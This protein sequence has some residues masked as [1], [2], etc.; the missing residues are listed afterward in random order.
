VR[1]LD[2]K[3]TEL[4]LLSLGDASAK[5]GLPAISSQNSDVWRVSNDLGAQVPLSQEAYVN[6]F[7]K[8]P[9]VPAPPETAPPASAPPAKP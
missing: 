1:A 9:D 4:G 6:L 8:K 5:D 3:G 2:A 7:V